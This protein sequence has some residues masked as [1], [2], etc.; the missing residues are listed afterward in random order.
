MDA[1]VRGAVGQKL[2]LRNRVAQG[3]CT[4]K[5]SMTAWAKAA[6]KTGFLCD[7]AYIGRFL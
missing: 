1:A 4:S 6:V 7:K 3:C 5:L 2:Y